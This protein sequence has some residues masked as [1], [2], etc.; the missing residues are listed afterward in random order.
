MVYNELVEPMKANMR[1]VFLLQK[2]KIV[3]R[4]GRSAAILPILAIARSR[5]NTDR[6][7]RVFV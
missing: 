7:F 3:A 1:K 5:F 2:G 4:E 6:P